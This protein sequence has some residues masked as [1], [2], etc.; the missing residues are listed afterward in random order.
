MLAGPADRDHHISTGIIT[1]SA[2]LCGNRLSFW[3]DEDYCFRDPTT[4][5][6]PATSRCITETNLIEIFFLLPTF[7]DAK[8]A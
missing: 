1:A 6:V 4:P 2:S 3:E 5:F 8:P 7:I